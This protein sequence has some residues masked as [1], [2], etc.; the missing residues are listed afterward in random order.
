MLLH[1][2][3]SSFFSA[4]KHNQ[5]TFTQQEHVSMPLIADSLEAK[6]SMAFARAFFPHCGSVTTGQHENNVQISLG[7]SSSSL[8]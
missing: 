4:Q 1:T 2:L 8:L 5:P 7:F 6:R 3:H